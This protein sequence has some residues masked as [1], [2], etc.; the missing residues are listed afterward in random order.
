MASRPL[1]SEQSESLRGILVGYLWSSRSQRTK[2][3]DSLPLLATSAFTP[4]DALQVQQLMGLAPD[5]A[6]S[7]GISQHELITD[8]AAEHA[9]KLIREFLLPHLFGFYDVIVNGGKERERVRELANFVLSTDKVRLRPS[10]F[11]AGV[12]SLRGEADN[13]LREWVGRLCAMGWINPEEAKQGRPTKAWSVAPGL[14]EHFAERRKKAQA[15]RA[16]AHRILAAGGSRGIGDS[17]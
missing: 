5:N 7:A 3:F 10:D 14:R 6:L 12:R 11:T 2:K 13:K 15:A 16:E 8:K 17:L 4:E 9:D 1:C